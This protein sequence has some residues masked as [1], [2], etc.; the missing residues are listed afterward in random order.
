ME[1]NQTWFAREDY[2]EESWKLLDPLLK[3]PP[4]PATY[5]PGTWGPEA[6]SVVTE[7]PGGWINPV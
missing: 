2:V 6:A 4:T 3:N 1:G 5:D 7:P